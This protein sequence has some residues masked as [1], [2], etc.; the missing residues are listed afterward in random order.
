[1]AMELDIRP[2]TGENLDDFLSFFE[3]VEFRDHPGWSDC[4]CYSFHFTG[5]PEQWT[6]ESN[7][8]SVCKLVRANRMK[9]YLAYHRSTPVGWCNVNNRL[10]YQRLVSLYDL[11]EPDSTSTCSIVCFL[12]HQKYRRSGIAGQLLQRIIEDYTALG[13]GC[14]EAYPSKGEF[15]CEAHYKGPLDL[16]LRNGFEPVA[17]FSDHLQVRKYLDTQASG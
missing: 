15:S 3:S 9:G 6:R 17:E 8:S 11:I 16:Y 10:R 12:I 13:Y 2:L 5:T 4:Y 14:I 1:M 7:R